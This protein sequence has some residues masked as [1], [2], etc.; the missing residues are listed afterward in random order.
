M[1]KALMVID[2]QEFTV[3][4][5]HAKMF[6][7]SSDLLEN[8]N[9]II[10]N[11]DADIVVY[12]R[13][14][15]KNSLLNK[16]TPFRCFDGMKEAELVEGLAVI[17]K[18]IFDKF[19]ANAFS[20]ASL[21]SFLTENKVSELEMIGVDGGGCVS[22]TAIGAINAGFKVRLNTVAIGTI[23]QKRKKKYFQKLEKMG[24]VIM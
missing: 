14:L 8:A 9:R 16:F 21:L 24:A 17:N 15:M 4:I 6:D 2:M 13:N 7:Y 18:N 10:N 3:G 5:N 20:N 23:F 1:R 22:L 11:T 12:I 19:E